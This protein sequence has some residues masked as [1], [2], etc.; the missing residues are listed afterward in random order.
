MAGEA[1]VEAAY[2]QDE[3]FRALYTSMRSQARINPGDDRFRRLLV[4]SAGPPFGQWVGSGPATR[5][6]SPATKS[7]EF[8]AVDS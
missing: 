1:P 6:E 8:A 7:A 4:I 2:D 3:E 5:L